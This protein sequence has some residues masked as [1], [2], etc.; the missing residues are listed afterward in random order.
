MVAPNFEREEL[1]LGTGRPDVNWLLSRTQ[2]RDHVLC[3]VTW[4]V[5][6]CVN[7]ARLVFL[8]IFLRLPRHDAHLFTRIVFINYDVTIRNQKRAGVHLMTHSFYRLFHSHSCRAVAIN[9]NVVH[10]SVGI[11]VVVTSKK[12]PDWWFA[13]T[14]WF[15]T[16]HG[17]QQWWRTTTQQLQWL[18]IWC[19][20]DRVPFESTGECSARYISLSLLQAWNEVVGYD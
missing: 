18:R 3:C 5:L 17:G 12:Y 15:Q 1:V 20:W 9:K 19:R 2:P 11:V 8:A 10:L 14:D 4:L 7:S 13:K 16:Q 6:Y